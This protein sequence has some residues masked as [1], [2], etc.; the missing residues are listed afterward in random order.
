MVALGACAD[1]EPLRVVVDL[2]SPE[3]FQHAASVEV[4]L[5]EATDDNPAEQ[6]LGLRQALETNPPVFDMPPI[7]TTQ[8][9]DPCDLFLGVDVLPDLRRKATAYLVVVR[10]QANRP[11][12]TGC[13]IRS[14]D[15]F[16]LDDT[17]ER[18]LTLV[19]LV[20]PYFSETLAGT[21]PPFPSAEARC[22]V[23]GGG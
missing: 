2:Q 4:T 9:L 3:V 17:G 12:A 22:G 18:V 21:T 13:D 11:I 16:A 15:E 19:T 7:R 10:D 8:M 20:T 5:H 6:C 1:T 23:M 14:L